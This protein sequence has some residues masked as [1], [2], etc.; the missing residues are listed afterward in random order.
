[1]FVRIRRDS[2]SFPFDHGL[3]MVMGLSVNEDMELIDRVDGQSLAVLCLRAQLQ[4]HCYHDQNQN[5]WKTGHVG[6]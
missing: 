5:P 1:M 3:L 2:L 4:M 6:T